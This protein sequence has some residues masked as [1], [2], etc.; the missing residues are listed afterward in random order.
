MNLASKYGMDAAISGINDLTTN[1]IDVKS[2]A[3]WLWPFN[4]E[5]SYVV[6]GIIGLLRKA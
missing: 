6:T 4:Y 5:K 1:I 3:W 2:R